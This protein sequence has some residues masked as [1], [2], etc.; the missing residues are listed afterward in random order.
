[1]I[2]ICNKGFKDMFS[3]MRGRVEQG[4]GVYIDLNP[5]STLKPSTSLLAN[6][7]L[8]DQC[9]KIFSS[10]DTTTKMPLPNRLLTMARSVLKSTYIRS[11]ES[12]FKPHSAFSLPAAQFSSTVRLQKQGKPNRKQETE[13]L[14]DSFFCEQK[15]RNKASKHPEASA[16]AL[17]YMEIILRKRID[18]L[19]ANAKKR[20]NH[21]PDEE[22][23]EAIAILELMLKI[24]VPLTGVGWLV[25]YLL[26]W[27]GE[28]EKKGSEMV[29]SFE[30]PSKREGN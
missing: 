1:M 8:R 9:L 4:R 3:K 14:L 27:K 17:H 2:W 15:I 11:L 6:L 20:G 10:N 12:R 16:L 22:T 19:R 30:V 13:S 29:M 23:L 26:F 24:C 28:S 7:K 21:N 5:H 18:R 25:W